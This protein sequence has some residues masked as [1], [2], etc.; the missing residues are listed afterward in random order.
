MERIVIDELK[1][2]KRRV[3]DARDEALYNDFLLLSRNKKS[4]KSEIIRYLQVMHGLNNRAN[5]Y[6]I[7]ERMKRIRTENEQ[8]IN[9]HASSN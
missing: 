7:I 2:S 8:N 5:V 3:R 6:R 4:M 1:S 9:D